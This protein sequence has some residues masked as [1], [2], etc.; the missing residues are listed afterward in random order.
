[1]IAEKSTITPYET[2]NDPGKIETFLRGSLRIHAHLDWR[3]PQE[4]F[5][6]PP[7]VLSYDSS[8]VT[9]ILSLAPDPAHLHW[10]RFFATQREEEY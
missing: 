7:C 1:M 10:V 4:W 8:S 3:R 2:F 6:N 9:S 5:N